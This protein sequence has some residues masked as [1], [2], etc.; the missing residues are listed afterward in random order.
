MRRNILNITGYYIPCTEVGSG[1]SPSVVNLGD[2]G[3]RLEISSPLFP[4][5]YPENSDCHWS[6]ETSDPELV[7]EVE[8]LTW[9]V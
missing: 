4:A 5:F 7:V 2:H 6:F 1:A 8:V 3:G 9:N